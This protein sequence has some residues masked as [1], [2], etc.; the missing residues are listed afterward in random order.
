M[1]STIYLILAIF[2]CYQT[3]FG[4]AL[5]EEN[6]LIP[7][8]QMSA[9]KWQ[10]NAWGGGT[11]SA[12]LV[13]NQK[14]KFPEFI[15]IKAAKT[16]GT[17]SNAALF[18]KISTSLK[19]LPVSD[20]YIWYR[21]HDFKGSVT[22]NTVY[23]DESGK[24]YSYS[25][26]LGLKNDGRWHLLKIGLKGWSRHRRPLNMNDFTGINFVFNGSGSI[27]IGGWGSVFKY[28]TLENTLTIPSKIIHAV[29][30]DNCNIKIDGIINKNEWTGAGTITDLKDAHQQSAS[31]NK[32]IAFIK[33]DSK[34]LYCAAKCYKDKMNQL[35]ADFKNNSVSIW[36]DESVEVSIDPG[37]TTI[38]FT[39]LT[40]NANGFFGGISR[41]LDDSGIKV[42][43]KKYK[44]RWQTEIF[45]PWQFLKFDSQIPFA[46]GININRNCY[47]HGKL[48]RYGWTTTVWNAVDKFGVAVF[49]RNPSGSN[50]KICSDMELGK[51]GT[52]RYI[53]TGKT[54][55]SDLSYK[56]SIYSPAKTAIHMK[57][58]LFNRDFSIPFMFKA[59]TSGKYH[60]TFMTWS[61]SGNLNFQEAT[62]SEMAY[63]SV[64]PLKA[65]AIALFPIPKIF[66]QK[67]GFVNI[68]A[69]TELYID[70]AKLAYC[71][72]RLTSVLKKFYNIEL[73]TTADAGNAK[74][75]IGLGSNPNI[76]KLLNSLKL[77]N[78]YKKIKYDGFVLHVSDEKI[79]VAANEKRGVLYGVN[80][81]LELIKMS[82]GDVGPARICK[83]T[84]FDWPRQ[85][86]RFCHMMM[87]SYYHRT[88][89]EPDFY[90]EM[91]ERFLIN[92]RFNGFLF[93]MGDYYKWQSVPLGS[94]YAWNKQ[95]YI[96][97]V[98]FIN[99]NYMPVMPSIQSHGHMKWWLFRGNKLKQFREDGHDDV[100]C[101]GHPDTY[102]MLFKI[103][104]E[105]WDICSRNPEFKPKYF[106]TSLDEVRWNTSRIP[107]E[108]R[109]RYCKGIPKNEIYLNHVKRLNSYI[110]KKG[111]KMMMC[112]DMLTEGH[113]GLNEF[114]CAEV[115]DR[116]PRNVIMCHWS[117][118]DFPSIGKFKKLG[119]ENWKF[120]TA[121]KESGEYEHMVTG[122]CFNNCTYNWWLSLNRSKPNSMYGLMAQALFINNCWNELPSDYGSTWRRL[123]KQYGN[124]MMRNWSRKPLLHA[125]S[126]TF[127]INLAQAVNTPLTGA[128]GWFSL[129]KDYDLS[130]MNFKSSAIAGIPVKFTEKQNIPQ[131]IILD[132]T[133]SANIEVNRKAASLILLH[134]A[135]LKKD[136]A[137]SFWNPKHYKDPLRGKKI[138]ECRVLYKDKTQTVFYIRYGWNISEWRINPMSMRD[139]FSKY[140]ADSRCIWE[141]KTPFATKKQLP[142][143]IALY[144]YEWVNPLPGKEIK[145]IALEAL[146]PA[147][148]YG[149]L[150]V[151]ARNVK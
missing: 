115:I 28:K 83:V 128:K 22:R 36:Q 95:D 15:E 50:A 121:Y 77:N 58:Q 16:R 132:K 126:K 151:S 133:A 68:A 45:I 84:V 26:R 40:V 81:L 100:L 80:A 129:G 125:G 140:L 1:K 87:H 39:K 62:V 138:V 127:P 64:K 105:D 110:N 4:K 44:D 93:E 43:S 56:M 149:L 24:S 122:Y 12:K 86:I 136:S 139:I 116:I 67:N 118:L 143:D 14:G 25:Y 60:I 38:S 120:L 89:Y 82:S 109:C 137:K 52:G 69:G 7:F 37:R 2:L 103:Y 106:F 71:G 76:I 131:G 70:K 99:R 107:K 146:E 9:G 20:F 85:E 66:K 108:K 18:R 41:S 73:K 63:A 117:A 30:V 97:V 42:A 51:I 59:K 11:L 148:S 142:D 144:Q 145:S 101:T 130:K 53:F 72:Q 5:K 102:K 134:G 150:A 61:R 49:S 94:A 90:N 75:V 3:G 119:F 21:C 114:K 98:D 124:Q 34:G 17:V 54:V 19:K 74:I 91:L 13:K 113:N 135:H 47:D 147:V 31:K 112:T 111:A 88:K 23:K 55:T 65:D 35:K 33:A 10:A 6:K 46:C 96:K 104:D 32:T 48:E 29:Y 123:T 79:L 141:G 92:F 78:D 27:D 8:A 57:G